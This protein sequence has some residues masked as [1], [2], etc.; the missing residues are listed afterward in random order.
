MI[1]GL[2][3]AFAIASTGPAAE[4]PH[5]ADDFPKGVGYVAVLEILPDEEGVAKTCALNSVQ[6]V[7]GEAPTAKISPSDTYVMDACR[8]LHTGK[9]RVK[10]DASGGIEM[11]Y[12]FCRYVE[13]SPDVAFCDRQLGE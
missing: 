11:Q 9:W 10:R 13:S 3:L 8:K 4:P 2:A 7:S 5:F 1:T 6:Q 12:Y